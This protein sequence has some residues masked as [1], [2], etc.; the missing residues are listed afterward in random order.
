MERLSRFCFSLLNL[1]LY[2]AASCACQTGG[3]MKVF[4]AHILAR[5]LT[6]RAPFV[7]A[8]GAPWLALA[9]SVPLPRTRVTAQVSTHVEGRVKCL[10]AVRLGRRTGAL[11]HLRSVCTSC[12]SRGEYKTSRPAG[13]RRACVAHLEFVLDLVTIVLDAVVGSG[14]LRVLHRADPALLEHAP[15]AS[16]R[17]RARR[18]AQRCRRSCAP[19]TFPC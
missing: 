14:G 2:T 18:R 7:P 19:R 15:E 17:L 10:L 6:R 11:G 3:S 9:A 8:A 5:M 16:R 1:S 4:S 13:L 12:V